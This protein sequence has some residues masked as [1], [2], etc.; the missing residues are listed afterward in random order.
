M[1][2]K[3]TKSPLFLIDILCLAEFNYSIC[4]DKMRQFLGLFDSNIG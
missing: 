4:Y 1:S 2:L 3:L